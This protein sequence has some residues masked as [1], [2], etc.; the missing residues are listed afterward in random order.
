MTKAEIMEAA[1]AAEA[2]ASVAASEPRIR[3]TSAITNP[4]DLPELPPEVITGIIRRGGKL[5]ISGASK[6]GK[7]FL[8]IE[9]AVAV[10][11]GGDWVGFRCSQGRVLYANLEIQEPQFL[12]RVYRT[13]EKLGVPAEAV[14]QNFDVANLRGKYSSIKVLV[15]DLL[16]TFKPG[17]YDLVIVDPAY[18]VQSGTENDADAITSFCGQLDRLAEGL[19]C[20]V[21]YTHHHSKGAQGNKEAQDRASGSGVFARDADALIDM[22][23]LEDDEISREAAELCNKKGAT[24]YRLEFVVRDFKTHEPREIWFEYPLHEVDVSGMLANCKP[25]KSGGSNAFHQEH[26]D[27]A[28][29]DIERKLDQFMGERDTIDR[30]DFARHIDMD[31]RTVNKYIDKSALFELES[32]SN[33]A[34]IHRV[35]N[36]S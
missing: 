18:K 4:E 11:T 2:S 32:R 24:P 22:I 23:R 20:T 31:A 17:A 1:E 33:V 28:L 3:T 36:D 30:I 14:S 12:H 21:V 8:L 27:R 6:S 5:L 34:L 26:S 10:A 19:A 9:L 13:Y 7:S 29:A 35:K 16:A 15:D 25:H